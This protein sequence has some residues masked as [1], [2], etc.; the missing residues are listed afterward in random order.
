MTGIRPIAQ[1]E[2]KVS[3]RVH[4]NP[5]VDT[6][7]R[8]RGVERL[9]E[10]HYGLAGLL[11]PEQLLGMDRA[12]EVILRHIDA[13]SNIM[14]LG[15]F[16]CDGA[17]ATATMVEGLEMLG[18]RPEY[19]VQRRELGYGLS[20]GVVELMIEEGHR[21]DLIITVDNGIS[22]VDGA[23]AVK[24]LPWG[25][26][27]VITDH[28]LPPKGELPPADAIVNPS[29]AGCP[30]PS[31]ALCGCGVAFYV[32]AALRTRMRELGRFKDRTEPRL[33]RLLDLVGLAT[34]A[35]MV[36]LDRNNR[37]LVAGALEMINAGNV[38]P[39]IRAL[40][41]VGKRSIG[42]IRAADFGFAVGPRLNA[43]GRLDSMVLG[44]EALLE[45]DPERAAERALALDETNRRRREIEGEMI[46]DARDILADRDPDD[47]VI[48]VY[49]PD[50][51][52]GVVGLVASRLKERYNLP[53]FAFTDTSATREARVVVASESASEAERAAARAVLDEAEI[54]GSARSIPGLHLKHFMDR[55][56]VENPGVLQKFGGHAGAAGCTL[57]H[58]DLERFRAAARETAEREIDPK[59]LEGVIEVDAVNP[60]AETLTIETA[61]L[62][63]ALGPWGQGFEEPRFAGEFEV[64]DYRVLK[65]VHLKL[66]LRPAGGGRTLEAIA[67]NVVDKGELPFRGRVELVFRL[68]VNEWNGRE[69][70]QLM[71]EHLQDREYLLERAA[72]EPVSDEPPGPLVIEG[73]N[74]K[75]AKGQDPADTRP[76]A[77][78]AAGKK[79][80]PGVAAVA[81]TTTNNNAL[82]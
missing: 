49:N 37:I 52:E 22:S 65:E 72:A 24:A 50:F 14:I 15:D 11:P 64:V 27:L 45:S 81:V 7:L 55:L 56:Q 6:I 33:S 63:G 43:A 28:H 26:D 17:T 23:K 20:P 13:G 10:V 2:A 9:E 68:D 29:Q 73:V 25:C 18:R 75:T 21:P 61:K 46:G 39:G 53:V 3:T 44:I 35:D 69:S 82:F 70:L 31:K 77:D 54:K 60:P 40:L 8:N 80:A 62:L 36:P 59:I 57:K 51:H 48:V 19:F 34:V 76:P 47:R 12:V 42:K 71:V 16:D 38:R 79:G 32:I 78:R 5:L 58:K 74:R 66:H 4:D 1:R 41:E 30:F 67:F